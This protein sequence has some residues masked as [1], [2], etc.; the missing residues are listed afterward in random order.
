[1]KHDPDAI[2]SSVQSVELFALSYHCRGGD[3]VI[4]G[5][6]VVAVGGVVVQAS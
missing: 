6:D 1:M 3:L 2:F 4:V 5:E